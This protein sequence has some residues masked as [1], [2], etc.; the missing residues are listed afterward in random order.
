MTDKD[1][2]DYLGSMQKDRALDLDQRWTNTHSQRAMVISKF[3]KWVAYPHLSP[4][5]RRNKI[6]KDQMPLVLRRLNFITKKW[7]KSPVK[8]RYLDRS[9]RCYLFEYCVGGNS[10][11]ACYHAMARDTSARP[12]EL[13][14]VRLGDI[15]IKRASVGQLYIL[16]EISRYGKK[17]KSRIVLM[18][19]S[20]KY[21]RNWRTV[22]PGAS[23]PKEAFLF[24]S[25]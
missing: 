13:L 15:E 2:T 7:S 25:T 22:H 3:F 5:G 21:Y 12:H 18:I 11:F 23:N 16:L 4:Q 14:D 17:K 10:R 6:P 8:L 19:D 20:V 1:L 9:R 24:I